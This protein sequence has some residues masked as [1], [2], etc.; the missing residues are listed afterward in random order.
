MVESI[1]VLVIDDH[2]HI[3]DAF[4]QFA[5]LSKYQ[6]IKIANSATTEK[7]ALN[8]LES[9]RFDVAVVDMRMA[10]DNETGLRIIESEARKPQAPKFL[11]ISGHVETPEFIIRALRIGAA[12][13]ML[14]KSAK[15]DDF[16]EAIRKIYRGERLFPQEVIGFVID[17][18]PEVSRLTKREQEV[19]QLI[20]EGLTVR[21]IAQEMSLSINTIKRITSELYAKIDVSSRAQ[22]TRTWLEVQYGL[23]EVDPDK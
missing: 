14:K 18:D 11:A 2:K 5:K 12:G 16:F 10:S 7:A 19:W 4:E 15:W 1:R 17:G 3:I 20:A 8:I 6:D 13:Y 21:Q 22:A 23:A 9:E